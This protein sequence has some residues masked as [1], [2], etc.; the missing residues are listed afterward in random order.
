MGK[1]GEKVVMLLGVDSVL[2]VGEIAAIEK[3]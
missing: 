3:E 2:S 1:V